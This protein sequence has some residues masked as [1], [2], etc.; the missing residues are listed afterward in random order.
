ME[1]M[2]TYLVCF[3]ALEIFLINTPTIAGTASIRDTTA[4]TEMAI[5]V[6]LPPLKALGLGLTVGNKE[7]S[8]CEQVVQIDKIS[9]TANNNYYL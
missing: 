1:I 4:T 7:W 3:F 8:C 2:S 5:A 9:H 6:I